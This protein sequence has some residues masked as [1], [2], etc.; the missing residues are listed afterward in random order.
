M[1]SSA[2]EELEFNTIEFFLYFVELT[3]CDEKSPYFN[4]IAGTLSVLVALPASQV[5]NL[6][7]LMQAISATAASTAATVRPDSTARASANHSGVLPSESAIL[8]SGQALLSRIT[9]MASCISPDAGMLLL[10]LNEAATL[11]CKSG[12]VRGM[13][14][15]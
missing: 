2:D 11:G 13:A 3:R 9:E 4:C 8:V 15:N 5:G 12:A 14:R 7:G 10:P 1:G 6:Q